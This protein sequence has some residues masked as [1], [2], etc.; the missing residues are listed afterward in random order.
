MRASTYT[1]IHIYVRVSN[2]AYTDIQTFNSTQ[3]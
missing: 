1:N 2:C 3:T